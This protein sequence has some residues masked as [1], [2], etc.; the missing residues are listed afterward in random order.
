MV[1]SDYMQTIE[2]IYRLI[3]TCPDPDKREADNGWSVK[4][5][6]GH[7]LDSLSNNHQRLLRYNEKGNLD[8][9]GYDQ[10]L[11][12]ERANYTAFDFNTLVSLWYNYNKLLLHIYAS[13]PPENLDST[14]KVGGR[15]A[16][17][18]EQLM[19][20]YFAHME[21]HEKQIQSIIDAHA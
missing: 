14:I 21:N 15:P 1:N 6:V 13:I 2:R 12:V 3:S 7:L 17:T 18:I 5:V 10:E 20:D 9:P 16:I 4:E 19:K 8:F 11:F